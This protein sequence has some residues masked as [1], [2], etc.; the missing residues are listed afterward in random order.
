MSRRVR[1]AYAR[2]RFGRECYTATDRARGIAAS[3]GKYPPDA[4]DRA[5][6][7]LR[8]LGQWEPGSIAR[9]AQA[10]ADMAEARAALINAI[11]RGRDGDRNSS[12]S[13]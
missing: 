11:H 6:I 12:R 3:Q 5:E 10:F 2:A 7:A 9:I 4:T 1:E 8:A 13:E